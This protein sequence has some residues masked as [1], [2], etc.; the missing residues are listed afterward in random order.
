MHWNLGGYRTHFLGRLRH[1]IAKL[2]YYPS[3]LMSEC[4]SRLLCRLMRGARRKT[5]L[6]NYIAIG[7]DDTSQYCSRA[8]KPIGIVSLLSCDLRLDPGISL[9]QTGPQ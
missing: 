6:V 8:S 5:P 2:M 3:T 1:N 9:L 4:H 7:S